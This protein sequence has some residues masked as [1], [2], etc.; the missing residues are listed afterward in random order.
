MS[1][2][3]IIVLIVAVAAVV[4]GAARTGLVKRGA[5]NRGMSLR[6]RFGPEYDRV[7]ARHNGDT[8]A[9]GHE[10]S[11]RV[12]RFGA[13]EAHPL[14]PHVREQYV[15]RWTAAQESFVE[16]PQE[17]LAEAERLLAGLA[18]ARGFPGPE[19]PDEHVA[20]LSVHHAHHIEGYRRVHAAAT[21]PGGTE[22]MRE[23]ML[24]ARAFFDA[25]AT[26]PTGRTAGTGRRFGRAGR[27]RTGRPLTHD[28][29]TRRPLLS[30][31]GN[32][33]GREAL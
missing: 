6:R 29:P 1:T 23:A 4:V 14:P 7:L 19:R 18:Q 16:S 27:A 15:T 24:Q 20:A 8:K 17:A 32:A 25:L 26:E 9:A 33:K 3:V 28:G 31:R 12:R 30:P 11:E 13:I 5:G 21:V 10:L 22:E 2:V